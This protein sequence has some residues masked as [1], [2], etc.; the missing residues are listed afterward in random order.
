MSREKNGWG[1][2]WSPKKKSL[3]RS[4][5]D[6]MRYFYFKWVVLFLVG[7]V[8]NKT[9]LEAG[10][11]TAESLVLLTKKAKKV[12][13]I[14]L[15]NDALALSKKIFTEREIPVEKYE[16]KKGDLNNIP[17]ADNTFD[18]VFNAGVIE[19]FTDLQPIKEMIRVA[20]PGGRVVILVPAKGLYKIAFALLEK[21]FFKDDVTW[22]EHKFYNRQMMKQELLDSG[23]VNI[24]ICYS[25]LSLGVYVVGVVTK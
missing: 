3:G 16:I 19:H 5:I 21:L 25:F 20:K 8:T 4:I 7:D 18:V 13:G 22:V 14:D 6:F 17:Y 9:V 10:C 11:G 23:A 2:Y 12:Y 24:K 15:S 1:N